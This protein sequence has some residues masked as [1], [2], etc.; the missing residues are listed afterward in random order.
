LRQ[1]H[2]QTQP[3]VNRIILLHWLGLK[4]WTNTQQWRR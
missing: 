1:R 2:K 3:Q 4:S